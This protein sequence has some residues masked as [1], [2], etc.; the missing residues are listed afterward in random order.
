LINS[1]NYWRRTRGERTL[2]LAPAD[3]VPAP[4]A[5]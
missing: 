1:T 4:W 3:G 2:R 5:T